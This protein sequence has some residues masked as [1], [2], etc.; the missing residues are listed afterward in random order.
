MG[1]SKNT[2]VAKHFNILNAVPF[3]NHRCAQ[4]SSESAAAEER[5]GSWGAAEETTAVASAIH[6][7]H[8]T[9]MPQKQAFT[10]FNELFSLTL[11]IK[12]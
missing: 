5:L 2:D 10:H 7:K 12:S 6:F 8:C 9:A 11:E 4:V 1:S 3:K